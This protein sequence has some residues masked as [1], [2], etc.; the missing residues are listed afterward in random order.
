[1]RIGIDIRYAY[2]HFPGIGRYIVNLVRALGKLEHQHTL[3]LLCNP[4]LPNTRYDLNAL[5]QMRSIELVTTAARPFSLWEQIQGPRLAR[6]LRL[7]VL[8][9]PYYIKP[10]LSAGC[11]SIVTIYDLIGRRYPGTLS[12]RGRYFYN[13]T[14]ALAVRTSARIITISH[15]ARDDIAHYYRVPKE[16][17]AVTPLAADRHFCPQP[18]EQIAAVCARYALPENYVLY[19]GSNKPHKNLE[20]L[21]RAWER[22]VPEQRPPSPHLHLVIA[23]HYDPRYPEAQA[24][25]AARKLTSSVHFLPNVA[26]ADMPALY[27]GATLFV[28]PSYYEG[29]GLPPLEAMACG[30]PVLCA[31]SSSLP[32]VVDDAAITFDPYNSI[33]LSRE[34][35]RLL[36]DGTL[37]ERLRQQGLQRAREFSWRRTAQQTLF[38][39]GDVYREHQR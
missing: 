25:V 20:R 23:G 37:R 26:E 16:R 35:R 12:R 36:N 3:V 11:P 9:S 38:V 4:A 32:E 15:S 33:E 6:A 30:T 17:I 34:L 27:S 2:D 14:M 7:D 22:I 5:G 13:L 18:A 8:H 21:I 29:F 39:Y 31:Y 10:Y 1:M 19:L 24:M 28:F